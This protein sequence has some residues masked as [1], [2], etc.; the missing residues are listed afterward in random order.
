MFMK[1]TTL[2]KLL[3]AGLLAFALFS[4]NNAAASDDKEED[5]KKE[6]EKETEKT[7]E[8]P[9]EPT[10]PLYVEF[11]SWPQSK[12]AEGVTVGATVEER[13]N[14]QVRYKGSDGALYVMLTENLKTE[15]YKVEPIKWR[16]ITYNYNSSGK[17]LLFAENILANCQFYDYSRDNL[18]GDDPCERTIDN[19]T[20]SPSNYEY[21]KVRA[22]LNGTSYQ[23]EDS[24]GENLAACDEFLNKGFL[25]QAFTKEEIAKIAISNIDNSLITTF[26]DNG[27]NNDKNDYICSNFTD[28]IFLLSEQEITRIKFGF[29]TEGGLSVGGSCD[30]RIRSKTD[31]AKGPDL[32]NLYIPND[33]FWWLRSPTHDYYDNARV[34]DYHG[35]TVLTQKG[36]CSKNYGVVPALCVDKSY[37]ENIK[38]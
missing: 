22:F 37:L 26:P 34:V 35:N 6:K 31:Y 14:G 4:C 10:E 7:P 2:L 19:K 23:K 21:S 20:I 3:L 27:W 38:I 32:P 30:L 5:T 33:E 28:K 1:K 11:G 25:Q 16:V 9:E 24:N 15:Y 29:D 36:S 13:V 17:A 12:R 18:P 8:Q